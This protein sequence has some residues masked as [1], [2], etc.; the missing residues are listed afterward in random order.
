MK[1]VYFT[2]TLMSLFGGLNAF[3]S[4]TKDGVV[5]DKM[6][7]GECLVV[8]YDDNSMPAN[9]IVTI[10]KTINIDGTDYTVS[11]IL[12]SKNWTDAGSYYN[13]GRPVMTVVPLLIARK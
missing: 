4:V 2:L 11:G 12:G 1:R 7:N 9:G 6:P 3:A 5:Y 8:N 13:N 10:A